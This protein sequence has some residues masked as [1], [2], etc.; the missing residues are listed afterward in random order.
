[1]K[2]LLTLTALVLAVYLATVDHIEP[3][4]LTIA[5]VLFGV[6]AVCATL[7]HVADRLAPPQTKRS[8]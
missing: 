8:K 7:L 3:Q 5:S 4:N 6:C 2:E 1:M